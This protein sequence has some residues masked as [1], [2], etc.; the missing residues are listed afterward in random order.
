MTEQVRAI[1]RRISESEAGM[2][3]QQLLGADA[4]VEREIHYP[5]FR[6]DTNC[7]LP[8][9]SGQ[10]TMQ[11]TVLVDAV[12]EQGATAD[13]VQLEDRTVAA[14]DTLGFTLT[15]DSA[16]RVARRY[17]AHHLGRRARAITNFGVDVGDAELIHKSF[18]IARDGRRQVMIDSVTGEAWPV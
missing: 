18:W 9:V 6:V 5:Y 13:P 1:R 10:Q 12:N 8:K 16:S 4:Q 14:Q 2:R 11:C 17:A 3:A 15:P 7:R